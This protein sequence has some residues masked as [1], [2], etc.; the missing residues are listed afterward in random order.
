MDLFVKS[1][2]RDDGK[3]SVDS[4]GL[5]YVFAVHYRSDESVRKSRIY[6]KCPLSRT[7]YAIGDSWTLL[8][9]RDLFDGK[10]RFNQIA[11]SLTFISPNVLSS[12]LKHLEQE[13]IVERHMYSQHPP[14]A[15]YVLTTKGEALRPLLQAMRKWGKAHTRGDAG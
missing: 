9:L 2:A 12:R 7:L 6:K 5:T 3:Q 1:L 15:E 14:R 11:E 10:L 13:G 4:S 8:V